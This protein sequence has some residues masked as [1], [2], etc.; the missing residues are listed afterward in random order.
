[1]TLTDP[2]QDYL[3]ASVGFSRLAETGST[4]LV[5]ATFNED[6]RPLVPFVDTGL[7]YCG[8]PTL[9][10]VFSGVRF[11][12]TGKIYIRAMVDNTEVQ[13]RKSVV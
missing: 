11:G 1:M 3:A 6:R 4:Q 7:I 5:Y 12:G 13:D 10:K 2:Y 8:D 9:L